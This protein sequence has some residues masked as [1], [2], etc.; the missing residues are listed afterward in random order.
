MGRPTT[1]ENERVAKRKNAER[2][3]KAAVRAVR[4]GAELVVLLAAL[5]FHIND[6]FLHFSAIPSSK[7][8]IK[9][10]GFAPD[11]TI[12]LESGGVLYRRGTG[13]L[14]TYSD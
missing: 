2:N 7:E 12:P 6:E 4:Y 3:R 5:I 14:R 9:Y 8:V 1:M 11:P 13:R 10:F